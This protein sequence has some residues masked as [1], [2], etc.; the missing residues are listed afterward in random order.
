MDVRANGIG[1][2]NTRTIRPSVVSGSGTSGTCKVTGTVV[3]R[4]PSSRNH[5]HRTIVITM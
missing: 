1:A 3:W 2:W 5:C 4:E